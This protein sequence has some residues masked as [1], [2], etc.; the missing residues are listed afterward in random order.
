MSTQEYNQGSQEKFHDVLYTKIDAYVHGVYNLTR[1]YPKE[2]LYAASSQ[3]RRAALSIMLNFLEGYARFRQKVLLNFLE[4]SY[5]SLKESQYLLAFA[6]AENW[7]S[8][9]EY[10]KIY[11]VGDE[12]ARMI[13]TTLSKIR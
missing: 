1:K 2:E 7:I 3:H 6:L 5:G 9:T 4:T 13:W 8:N 12:I 10:N 11:A